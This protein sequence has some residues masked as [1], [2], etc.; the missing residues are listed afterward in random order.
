[1]IFFNILLDPNAISRRVTAWATVNVCP[2]MAGAIP[3]DNLSVH[4]KI[5]MDP[6]KAPLIQSEALQQ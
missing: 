2:V 1:M 4:E 6:K 3:I 5:V